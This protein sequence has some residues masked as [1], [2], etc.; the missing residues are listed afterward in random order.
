MWLAGAVNAGEV[1]GHCISVKDVIADPLRCLDPKRH[2]K[3]VADIRRAIKAVPHFQ[4]GDVAEVVPQ[5]SAQQVAARRPSELFRY[6][7]IQD[8]GPG[9]YSTVELRGWHL[10]LSVEV[11]YCRR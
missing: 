2:S 1:T 9:I 11:V 7:E 10:G 4:L 3:K 5:L 6:V 8:T